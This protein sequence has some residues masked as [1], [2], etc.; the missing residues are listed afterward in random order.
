MSRL[1][2]VLTGCGLLA[3]T[4]WLVNMTSAQESPFDP[5]A[6]GGRSPFGESPSATPAATGNPF[7]PTAPGTGSPDVAR[8][9][10]DDYMQRARTAQQ[11]G[12]PDQAMLWA[13]MAD[14]MARESRITFRS[15]ET[16]PAQYVAQLQGNASNGALTAESRPAGQPA[17]SQNPFADAAATAASAAPTGLTSAS[18][19]KD[20]ANELMRLARSAMAQGHYDEARSYA[21]EA[22]ELPVTYDLF[23]EQP[24]NMLAEIDRRSGTSLIASTPNAAPAARNVQPQSQ[25]LSLLE[26]ARQDAA[27]GRYDEAQAKLDQ[28]RQMDVAYDLFDDRPELVAQDIR[29]SQDGRM[30]ANTPTPPSSGSSPTPQDMA[31]RQLLTQARQALV[32]GQYDVASQKV[33]EAEQYD[34]AY[35]A[36]EDTPELVREDLQRIA[37]RA[38]PS[39]GTIAANTQPAVP[40]R[41]SQ[42]QQA[43]AL[44]AQAYD[45]FRSGNLQ[46]ARNHA[47][48]A[49][50]LDVTYELF[51]E[52]P[53]EFIAVIDASMT[54]ASGAPQYAAAPQ[55][56]PFATGP[57][58][59]TNDR[60]PAAAPTGRDP[61]GSQQ[62]AMVVRTDGL[63]ALDLYNQGIE[64]LRSG[65]RQGAYESFLAAY[66]S[67]E[68]LDAYRQQQLQDK[69]RE[70]SPR[71]QIQ[72]ASSEQQ[73]GPF[74]APTSNPLDVAA[75]QQA[76]KFD[77]LRTD[78]LNSI[79]RAERLRDTDPQQSLQVLDQALANIS[80]AGLAETDTSSLTAAVQNSRSSIESYMSQRAPLIEL[81]RKNS[82]VKS[83]I[84]REMQARIRV[85]Q[86]IAEL[87]NQ[88]NQLMEQ[89][90]F[91]E[92]STVAQKAYE[93][94][95]EN[96]VVVNMK[97]KSQLA[98]RVDR[99][100]RLRDEKE[101]TVWGV[102]DDT[103]WALTHNVRDGH[104]MDYPKD[105]NELS[106]RRLQQYGDRVDE[107]YHSP[108]EIHVRKS[109]SEPVSLHFEEAPIEQ[110]MRHIAG[111]HGI[112][113]VVDEPGLQEVGV[114]PYTPVTINVDG[115]QLKSALNL[116]LK[117]LNL[118]YTIEDEVL[119]VTSEMRQQGELLTRVYS[120]PDLVTPLQL[121]SPQ[122]QFAPGTG[123]GVPPAPGFGNAPMSVNSFGGAQQNG[124]AQVIDP[125]TGQPNIP[126]MNSFPG[127]SPD[128]YG[129]PATSNYE[130]DA[131]TDLI[132]TTV[133]PNGWAEFGGNG[134]VQQH[135]G[136][137]SLVI[138]Q[139]QRVH[140]E[141][142]DLL[143]QLRR[144]QDLQV[145]IEVRFITVTDSFFERIGIDFD[146]NVNDS[147]GGPRLDGNLDPLAPFGAVD[148]VNGSSGGVADQGDQGG[149]QG[150]Q[151]QQGQTTLPPSN[152]PFTPGPPLNLV[153]RDNWNDR[154]V[155]GMLSPTVFS[156]DLD[157]PFR[158]G[159]FDI[160]VPDFGG[161]QA[162]AGLTFGAAILSDIE[163]FLFVQAAQG[164]SRSNILSAPK[165]TLFNGLTGTV[166]SQTQQPFVISLTPVVSAFSVGF[167]P[168]I[169]VIPDGVQLTVQAVVSADRRY[170]RLSVLPLF[171]E[172]ID[173]FTFTTS[174][175]VAA[176][177]G[178]G[179]GQ[180][181]QIG[182][183]GAIGQGGGQQGQQGSANAAT[184]TFQQPV[185][186]VTSVT[187]VVSVPD[188]G[189][190]LLGGLKQL[191][192][193]RN[194]AGVPI[195][196]KLPY[197]SRL[198]KNSGVGRD[199][200]SLMLLVTPRIIIQEE[201]EELLGIPA[202]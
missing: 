66:Q 50:Q 177:G 18:T 43:D 195:L 41:E 183:G 2:G 3:T 160:G 56:N 179:F 197:I 132:T 38:I 69:I 9:R 114:T 82:E 106:T 100:E 59:V 125:V 8:R 94:D 124:M 84:E 115:I 90:R 16:T 67:G 63:S 95:P 156:P 191:S 80:S 174:G 140:Q 28:A 32:A 97:L 74:A 199:T 126:S 36:F 136:T 98:Y 6:S 54:P 190:V 93:L 150:Q 170:V 10:V 166:V 86:D 113:V 158:N 55:D 46:S 11:Q 176:G 123:Y 121:K 40:S 193:S 151:A 182:Q 157:I 133:D 138:R 24:Q 92:A 131:L 171:T 172:I 29:T 159:S 58:D 200:S 35:T 201:E 146:W 118:S 4:M 70:L 116:V 75:N 142:A 129:G 52:S 21:L 120:V 165:I 185:V 30:Y 23:E 61:F 192:E 169:A 96:P 181:G 175:G 163:A 198:F 81:E 102:L 149:Q 128:M 153:G 139:T 72:Q 88:F 20:Q 168:Q 44:M 76:V 48:Q 101:Q 107:A 57:L 164:D 26:Q 194:M 65:E 78:V 109:L 64:Y 51:E 127:T 154:T 37:S 189:T 186:N 110:L 111:Q 45:A 161:F 1:F 184:V 143:D 91:A 53:T 155:V 14:K 117:P 15:G 71:R 49:S 7:A 104:E 12:E 105:W 85:E 122:S 135:E 152:A 119:K 79:F 89:N 130:F 73:A 25:A 83:I 188:G 17:V 47:E 147:V 145:T 137:L 178:G 173:V 33:A 42:R 13:T 27:A 62:D 202:P 196:N 19:P 22:R 167:Q 68:Q 141:I 77:R 60:A 87:V 134:Y 148:P 108:E 103:E 5:P 144:L 187:T 39:T 99:N 34:V 112:N 162:N 180:G 31:A